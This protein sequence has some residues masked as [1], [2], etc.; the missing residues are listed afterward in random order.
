VEDQSEVYRYTVLPCMYIIYYNVWCHK[1]RINPPFQKSAESFYGVE[2]INSSDCMR[3]QCN[4]MISS[5]MT[6][7]IEV[8]SDVPLLWN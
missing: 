2:E 8:V 1:Q 3:L 6:L 7:K 4:V 5:L